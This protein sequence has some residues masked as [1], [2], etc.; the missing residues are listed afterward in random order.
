MKERDRMAIER[1]TEVEATLE[2]TKQMLAAQ[3]LPTH[4]FCNIFEGLAQLKQD[5]P[6]LSDD[7]LKAEMEG[8]IAETR[9][10]LIEIQAMRSDQ[11]R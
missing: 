6:M 2:K 1:L 10:A 3:G 4:F 9:E 11:A 8:L 5:M 7:A